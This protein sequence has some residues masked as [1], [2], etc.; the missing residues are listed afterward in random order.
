MENAAKALLIA[1]GVLVAIL[2]L[3]I[4]VALYIMF[5]GQAKNYNIIVSEIETDKFNSNFN[6]FLGQTDIKAEEIISIVNKAKEY[7]NEVTVLVCK[8]NGFT[9]ISTASSEEFLQ[10]YINT[11]FKCDDTNVMYNENGKITKI[12]FIANN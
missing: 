4:G 8:K 7:N 5:S 11:T 9:V 12:K 1:A 6:V 2:I 10:D 3:T